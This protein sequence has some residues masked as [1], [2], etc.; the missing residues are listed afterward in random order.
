MPDERGRDPRIGRPMRTG[1]LA[2]G[3]VALVGLAALVPLLA[4]GILVVW[5][6][7]A[8]TVDHAMT[9]LVLRR[10][11]AGHRRSDVPLAVLTSPWH[12]FV[13][14]LSTALAM[15][16]PLA[17]AGAAVV[18]T[19]GGL[20]ESG[21]LRVGVEHPLPIAVGTLL[22][23]LMAWWGPG[24]LSMRRGSRTMVRTIVPGD[25]SS[26]VVATLLVVGGG[27][28]L[29]YCLQEGSDVSW[30]P[31]TWTVAPFTDLIPQVLR[32]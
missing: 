17:F 14:V 3:L 29:V 8:R 32:P 2:A 25:L 21:L 18:I 26:K 4:W 13:A 19:A 28:L 15:I 10:Y 20:T 7:G 9:A 11:E 22:G 1:T 12:L 30:W 27:V 23:L 16:L 31:T 24:G 6:I 5:A